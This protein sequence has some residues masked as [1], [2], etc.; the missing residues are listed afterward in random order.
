MNPSSKIQS[1]VLLPD[2]WSY[3]IQP[4]PHEL[5]KFAELPNYFAQN[6]QK[7][8]FFKLTKNLFSTMYYTYKTKL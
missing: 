7:R 4:Q 3:D 5:K 2:P 6:Y 8:N 1:D